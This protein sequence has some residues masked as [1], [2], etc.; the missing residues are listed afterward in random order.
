MKFNMTIKE[1]CKK[2]IIQNESQ[3]YHPEIFIFQTKRCE[4]T[5]LDYRL[6]NLVK[7][8][9]AIDAVGDAIRKYGKI[10]TIEDLIVEDME[11]FGLSED[12][13]NKAE[14]NVK[15]YDWLRKNFNNLR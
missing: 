8:Q 15:G 2:V 1:A 14:E 3:G 13:R 4:A 5:D 6:S 11:G 12:I 7:S 10:L 9:T